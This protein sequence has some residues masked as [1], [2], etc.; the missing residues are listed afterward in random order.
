MPT[1]NIRV[2][3]SAD[4]IQGYIYDGV[5]WW[6]SHSSNMV[7]YQ[8]ANW[9]KAGCGMRFLGIGLPARA[10]V[11]TAY[12]TFTALYSAA[13]TTVNSVITGEKSATPATFADDIA[14]YKARRDSAAWG[15]D[16]S[17]VTTARILYNAIGSW[18]GE[19]TYNSPELKTIIQELINLYNGIINCVLFWDDHDGLGTQSDNVARWAYSYD[20]TPAKAPLLT[21]VY[22]IPNLITKFLA[23]GIL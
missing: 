13:G 20:D 4:D 1:V 10:I 7:G 23:G 9:L 6:Y 21:V 15:G 8:A 14:T 22:H 11:D 12:L 5:N 3:A 17:T 16:E 19:A 18:T 2:A